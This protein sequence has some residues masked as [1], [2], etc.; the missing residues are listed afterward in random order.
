MLVT[1][2]TTAVVLEEQY[3]VAI[4]EKSTV[5]SEEETAI[6]TEEETAIEAEEEAAIE[7]REEIAT[8]EDEESNTH[9]HEM[10]TSVTTSKESDVAL[11]FSTVAS[12]W[13]F[14]SDAVEFKKEIR[15]YESLVLVESILFVI[16]IQGW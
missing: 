9:Y 16:M 14:I 4:E 12:A 10:F 11:N 15:Y 1:A 7:T 2:V 3:D 8:E 5:V 13:N 6:E